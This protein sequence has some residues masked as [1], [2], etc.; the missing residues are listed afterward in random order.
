MLITLESCGTAQQA[1]LALAMVE[2]DALKVVAYRLVGRMVS[3]VACKMLFTAY[4]AARLVV[5]ELQPD[6]PENLLLAAI[7]ILNRWALGWVGA[8]WPFVP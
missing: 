3:E 7:E 6:R 8:W 1:A 2:D 4:A 5:P